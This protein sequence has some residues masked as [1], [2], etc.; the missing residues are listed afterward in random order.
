MRLFPACVSGPAKAGVG[1]LRCQNLVEWELQLFLTE[2]RILQRLAW[3]I[4]LEFP[5]HSQ[6]SNHVRWE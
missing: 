3:L 1:F 4:Q 2:T 5:F 6:C